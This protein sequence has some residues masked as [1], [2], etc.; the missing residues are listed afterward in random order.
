MSVATFEFEAQ[1]RDDLGK[2]AS[3]RL[4]REEKV[5]GVL[6][7]GGEAATSIALEQR[8]VA[9][10]LENEAVYSHILTLNLNG[11]KHKV[12]L[13]D[14]QRHPYKAQVLHMDF[15]RVKD[16]DMLTMTT[17]LHFIGADKCPGV[18]NGGIL[19]HLMSEIEIRCQA[20]KLPEFIEVD[21]SKLELD[22]D[23]VLSNLKVPAGVEIV[24]LTLGHDLPVASVHLPRQTKLDEEEAAEEAAA[25]A[26]AAEAAAAEAAAA[27]TPA[28]GAAEGEAK[29]EAHK[30]DHKH[31]KK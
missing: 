26:A 21:V 27:G 7:G 4:R 31:D 29:A 19:N 2:S 6:Y 3:R 15:M 9:K 10:A 20:N 22:Q 18:V 28:E 16:S 1:K 5:L 30:D 25:A 8:L 11:K 23:I 14:I 17:P 24:Q 12:I 13:R